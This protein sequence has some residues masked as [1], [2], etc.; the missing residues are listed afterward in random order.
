MKE[1][2]ATP[3]FLESKSW[4]NL[5]SSNL[6][7]NLKYSSSKLEPGQEHPNQ[8]R[9]KAEITMNF[10]TEISNVLILFSNIDFKEFKSECQH[11]N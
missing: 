9:L 3:M 10:E 8:I 11:K 1:K 5:F 2:L 7:C 6:P 4:E